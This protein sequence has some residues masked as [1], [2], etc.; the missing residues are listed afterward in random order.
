VLATQNNAMLKA[1]HSTLGYDR[2][3]INFTTSDVAAEVIFKN[4]YSR[5]HELYFG[6]S[7]L[8]HTSRSLMIDSTVSQIIAI[9]FMGVKRIITR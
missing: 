9:D 3:R 4:G 2:K 1:F 5:K 7:Y 8:S 6:S